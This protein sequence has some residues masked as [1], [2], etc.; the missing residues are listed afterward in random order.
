MIGTPEEEYD[1]NSDHT[2]ILKVPAG[3]DKKQFV[4]SFAM[5]HF[6]PESRDAL[7]FDF[8]VELL[9]SDNSKVVGSWKKLFLNQDHKDFTG[10]LYQCSRGRLQHR[11]GT[12]SVLEAQRLARPLRT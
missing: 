1:P 12:F 3:I 6:Q 8:T 9:F 11:R 2:I 10:A 7:K 5:L 4:K